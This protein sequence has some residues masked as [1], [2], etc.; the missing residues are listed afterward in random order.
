MAM[1]SRVAMRVALVGYG[2]SGKVFHAPV[3]ATVPDL[4]LQLI[5][6]R[7]ADLVAADWPKIETTDSF[8]RVLEDPEI[9]LVVI[10]SPTPAHAWQAQAALEAGKHVVV[11]KPFTVKSAEAMSLDALAR[12]QRRVLSV[13]HNRRW[14]GD[15]RTI[16]R[17]VEDGTLGD[18]SRF[19]AHFDRYRMTIPVRWRDADAPGGGYLYDLGA[20]LID[21]VLVLFGPP[22]T[23]W[24]D[25]AIRRPGGRS[26][27]DLHVVFA[28]RGLRAVIRS[29]MMTAQVGPRYQIHGTSGSFLKWGLDPQEDALKAGGRPGA[30][31]W[32]QESPDKD[33]QL[34]VA[35]GPDGPMQQSRVPTVAGNYATYYRALAQAIRIGGPP[36]VTAAE[37]AAVIQAIEL[38]MLSH[39]EGRRVP[40]REG[41]TIGH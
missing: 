3:I 13:F 8:E 37:G 35:L 22:E 36:P 10:A 15:F 27:D 20:H 29:S 32:G 19:E 34:T 4:S 30:R 9:D 17:L 7:Q 41:R 24:A 31:G 14:D 16:Q 2:L 21:Q 5:V 38:A 39:R 6:T 1:G 23:V 25:L 26:V 11:E 28:Y 33:G 40:W 12:S 18:I